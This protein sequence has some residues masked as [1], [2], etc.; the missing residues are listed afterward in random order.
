MLGSHTRELDFPR[1]DTNVNVEDVKK[2]S[3]YLHVRSAQL[4][5]KAAETNPTL[6]E[7]AVYIKQT[8]IQKSRLAS[9]GDILDEVA[10]EIMSGEWEHILRRSKKAK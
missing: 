2:L 7:S 10:A 8:S 3:D 1:K 9:Q 5:L 4:R 6:D